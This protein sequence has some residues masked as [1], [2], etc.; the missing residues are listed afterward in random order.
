MSRVFAASNQ[1]SGL[2]RWLLC[3]SPLPGNTA[4]AFHQSARSVQTLTLGDVRFSLA[5]DDLSP[6][7]HA[8][9]VERLAL[10]GFKVPLLR[11][12][13]DPIVTL[14]VGNLLRTP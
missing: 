6:V 11:G 4:P 5:D 8:Q 13:T 9:R 12:V 2:L 3:L 7:V 1:L 14:S 10:D